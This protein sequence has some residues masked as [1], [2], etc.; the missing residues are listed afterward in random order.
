MGNSDCVKFKV[1]AL[2]S[3]PRHPDPNTTIQDYAHAT[4]IKKYKDYF[5]IICADSTDNPKIAF[6]NYKNSEFI[7]KPIPILAIKGNSFPADF[8]I[9]DDNILIAWVTRKNDKD[10]CSSTIIETY[11]KIISK[12]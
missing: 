10:Y 6:W 9:M 1:I 7:I 8:N 11:C 12:E 2:S 5:V 3:K 4:R